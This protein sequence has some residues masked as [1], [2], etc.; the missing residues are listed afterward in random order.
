MYTEKRWVVQLTDNDDRDP[1]LLFFVEA[2]DG[3]AAGDIALMA[4]GFDER[5]I[6]VLNAY[7]SGE[8]LED[9]TEEETEW[10][11]NFMEHKGIQSTELTDSMWRK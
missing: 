10:V 8:P 4:A 11:D 3:D 6:A 1:D 5:E 7:W 2:P 9:Q